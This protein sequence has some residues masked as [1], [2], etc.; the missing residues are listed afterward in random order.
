M[1]K[2]GFFLMIFAFLF[3]GASAGQYPEVGDSAPDFNLVGVSGNEL[4]LSDYKGKKNVILIFYAEN[5]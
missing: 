1:K 2:I 5:S 4:R 3:N